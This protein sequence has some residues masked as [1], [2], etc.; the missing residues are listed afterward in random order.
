MKNHKLLWGLAGPY[1]GDYEVWRHE[2]QLIGILEFISEQGFKSS[3]VPLDV[4]QD[5]ERAEKVIKIIE[6]NN[7]KMTTGFHL[8]FFKNTLDDIKRETDIFLENLK[9]YK[10]VL[11]IQIVT[12]CV[13]PYHRFMKSPSFDEQMET[14]NKALAPIAKG[15]YDLGVPF[16]IEN[17]GDYYCSDLVEL[18]KKTPHLGIFLDTGN[19]FLI[20]E[21][22]I[23][24]YE[25]AAPYVIGTH[26]KDHIVYPDP[27]ELKLI[28][29]GA[30]LGDGH[31]ELEKCFEILMKKN[32]NPEKLVLHWELIKPDEM[33]GLES[34][35]RSWNFVEKLESK[36][37]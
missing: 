17:H 9:K 16:G 10:D 11:K 21:Q 28:I 29:K 19:C 25:I 27:V 35:Q 26:F 30:S 15:C 32:P 24:A 20:G 2:D 18:C 13:G 36:Y 8:D 31:A 3:S 33:N 7:L 34:I 23:P 22:P 4:M 6:D 5:P 1:Y 37:L 14:L 12:T